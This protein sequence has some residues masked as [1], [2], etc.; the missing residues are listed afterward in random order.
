MTTARITPTDIKARKGQKA[1][2][3]L[4]A[5]TANIARILDHHTDLLLV[6]DSLGMVLYGM[7]RTQG[8]TLDMMV[9]HGKAV[10]QST[11]HACI[12]V[13]MP[14][15]SY[16]NDI[17]QA[18]INA[19]HIIEETHCQAVKLEGGKEIKETIK[20]LTNNNIKVLSHIGLKP[21]TIGEN[22]RF[23]YQ[24]KTQAQQEAIIED[25]KAVEEA[26]AFAVVLECVP[27]SLATHI[28][29]IINIPTIAIGGSAECDG[30]ILV[31]DDMLGITPSAPRFVKQYAQLEKSIETAV[32]DYA[33]EVRNRT[34]PS[35]EQYYE[36]K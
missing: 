2:V 25:A 32:K 9:R 27:A 36:P 1:I 23:S 21:Q 14:Y 34:F 16:E 22:D 8:V 6:G 30:Q 3:C 20:L 35:Q 11:K 28:T 10:V 19:Q 29:N 33:T 26:G 4:T 24:G 31:T 15:G 7:E 18:I 12:V 17:N 5:Y 13:D